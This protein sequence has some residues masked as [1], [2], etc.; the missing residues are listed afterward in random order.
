MLYGSYN[1]LTLGM[2]GYAVGF[3]GN[4]A[5]LILWVAAA[6]FLLL[7]RGF[8]KLAFSQG[9]RVASRLVVSQLLYVVAIVAFIDGERSVLSGKSPL[10]SVGGAAPAVALILSGALLVLVLGRV[11]VQKVN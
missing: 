7:V 11:A 4:T 2:N 6:L 3:K 1:N 9:G 5:G 10:F 8:Y